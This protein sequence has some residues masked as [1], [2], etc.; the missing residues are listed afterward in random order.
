MNPSEGCVLEGVGIKGNN[1]NIVLEGMRYMLHHVY[2]GTPIPMLITS[3]V[4]LPFINGIKTIHGNNKSILFVQK[5]SPT[6]FQI[7]SHTER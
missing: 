7:Q 6:L 3:L 4:K 1:C 5:I 2:N